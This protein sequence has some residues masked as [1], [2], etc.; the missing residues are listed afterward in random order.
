MSA[1]NSSIS[2]ACS[3]DWENLVPVP[4]TP[5]RPVGPLGPVFVDLTAYEPVRKAPLQPVS[6]LLQRNPDTS[7]LPGVAA[8]PK[9][10]GGG[11][12]NYSDK[13]RVFGESNV[14][15]YSQPA[16]FVVAGPSS[17]SF[18]QYRQPSQIA[19][20]DEED[21]NRHDPYAYARAASTNAPVANEKMLSEL[22]SSLSDDDPG[23]D[24]EHQ[25]EDVTVQLLPHQLKGVAWMKTREEGNTKGGILAD[26][27]GLGKT[28]QTLSLIVAER[29]T[30][31]KC[32]TTLVVAPLALLKQWESELLTKTKN[33]LLK[34]LVYHGPS[35]TKTPA[36]F[37]K[38]DVVITTFHLVGSEWPKPTKTPK[39][40]PD[41]DPELILRKAG[42]LFKFRWFRVVLDEA[43]TIKNKSTKASVGA[44]ALQ[45]E[46]RWC[47]TGTPLQ[48]NVDEFYSLLRFLRFHPF[49]DYPTYKHQITVPVTRGRSTVGLQRLRVILQAI[50]L[51]R[52]KKS[53]V[54]GKPLLNLPER[55]VELV[56][57]EMTGA[58]REF[59]DR[60]EGTMRDRLK[61]YKKADLGANYA[62]ILCLLLR[63]RQACNHRALIGGGLDLENEIQ[64]EKASAEDEEGLDEML[65]LFKTMEVDK[66]HRKCTICFNSMAGLDADATT[67][68][69]CTD[70]FA[71]TDGDSVLNLLP[72]SRNQ[73]LVS[74][75]SANWVT[76][77]K[78]DR[79]LNEISKIHE[80]EP[81]DKIIIFSQFTSMLDVVEMAFKKRGYK[82][83]RYDGSMR[84]NL[85]ENSL[86]AIRSDNQVKIL[87]I[88]LKCGSLGLNLI[89]ANRVIMLDMWWNPAIEDQ[90]IDRVHRIGQTKPVHVLRFAV[91]NSVEDRILAMQEKKRLLINGALG[92]DGD[93]GRKG[94]AKKMTMREL[95]ALF[96]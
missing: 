29:S 18:D 59:Y 91:A 65:A 47:L 62:S 1:H 31:K 45:T 36:T 35:R 6:R 50:M 81:T 2:I 19:S 56:T 88:S 89:A 63:L 83:A 4:T 84:N 73:A 21:D 12:K 37:E 17:Q 8:Y 82:Y 95:V 79:M 41:P 22:L 42:P 27:M 52:T 9:Y 30:D 96:G 71:T 16:P 34:V 58:E 20:D 40:E 24:I 86:E 43:Q 67:C 80:A 57:V 49:D 28:V 68:K 87:L 11:M 76:S 74:R 75:L 26:D 94:R 5:V 78:L 90:A 61:E 13:V 25:P 15:P 38:Y 85:R 72:K 66:D 51:R 39:G 46:R 44:S 48:N 33:G 14:K 55:R 7:R 32:K 93:K 69:E 60:L 92:D 3:E 64:P 77:A 23:G 10:L 53:T 54:D 70:K